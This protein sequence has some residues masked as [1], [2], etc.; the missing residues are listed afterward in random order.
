MSMMCQDGADTKPQHEERKSKK[1]KYQDP[2]AVCQKKGKPGL[3]ELMDSDSETDNSD[4]F[5]NEDDTTMNSNS[6][7]ELGGRES[8]ISQNEFASDLELS[9][10]D[11]TDALGGADNRIP[12]DMENSTD[13]DVEELIR[14]VII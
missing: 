11:A 4:A 5:V 10:M 7:N 14:Y 13:G 1:R 12:S 8:S 3:S 2:W 6:S 9:G